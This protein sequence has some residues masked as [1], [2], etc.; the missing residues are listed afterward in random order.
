MTLIADARLLTGEDAERIDYPFDRIWVRAAGNGDI[1]VADYTSTDRDGPPAHI[2]PW[3][4]LQIVV[5]GVV[6]FSLG[7]GPW[8]PGGPGSVQMLPS[9][10]SHSLRIPEGEARILQVSIGP[11]YAPFA[12]DMA[13]LMQQG[14]ALA[15]IAD[16]AATHGVRLA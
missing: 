14:A 2:H 16:V 12:R 4:E 8:T 7:G 6:E 3:D 5:S 1:E 9:G 11:P 15:T 13:L 10:H